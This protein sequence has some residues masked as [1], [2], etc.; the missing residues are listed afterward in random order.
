[1]IRLVR[2]T[3]MINL[4]LIMLMSAVYANPLPSSEFCLGGIRPGSSMDY[5]RSIYGEPKSIS[6]KMV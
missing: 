4:V 3:L 2:Y 1:M 5:V 6:K